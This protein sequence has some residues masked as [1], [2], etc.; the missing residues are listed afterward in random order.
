VYRNRKTRPPVW[1]PIRST[2]S[3]VAARASRIAPGPLP[4]GRTTTQRLA[5]AG[6][7]VFS[8]SSKPRTPT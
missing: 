2:C 3:G 1:L 7:S 5:S 4:G 8:T 6:S